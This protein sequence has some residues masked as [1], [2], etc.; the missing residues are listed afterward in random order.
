MRKLTPKEA[1]RVYC[2]QCLGMKQRNADQVRDCEGD[3]IKCSFFPYRLGKRP[4]VKVFRKYC[5]QDCMNGYREIVTICTTEDCE[6]YPYRMGTNPARTGLG[7]STEIMR[8][9]REQGKK[10]LKPAIT[11]QRV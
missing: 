11:Y 5:L 4:P 9:V 1:I 3:Y 10:S 7:A 8:K 6:C 2:V